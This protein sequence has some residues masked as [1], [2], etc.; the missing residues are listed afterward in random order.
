VS[1]NSIK[2]GVLLPQSNEHQYYPVSFLNGLRL[3]VNLGKQPDD[4]K[5]EV[6][7][8]QVN[9]GNPGITQKKVEQLITENKV[10]ML[11]GL[12]NYEVVHYIGDMVSSA[13]VPAIIAN[14]GENYL[15]NNLKENPYLFFN[16]LNLCRNSY[17]AGKYAVEKYGKKIVVV[18]ALYD[19]G[20]DALSAF[21]K[22][23]ESAGG[24]IIE[25][26]LKNSDDKEFVPKTLDKIENE[27]LDGIYVFL[28]GNLADEFFRTTFQRN[29]SVPVITTSFVTDDNRLVY[30]GKAAQGVHHFSTWGKNLNNKENQVFVA[31]YNKLFSK[32]PDQFGFLGYESGLIINNAIVKCR[33]DISGNNLANAIANCKIESPGGQISVNNKTGFV[34]NPAYLCKTKL[35]GYNVPENVILKQYTQVGEF[36]EN[37]ISSDTK[38]RSGFINPYLF[39]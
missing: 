39:V 7:T 29:L 34:N 10:K 21:Y 22:G 2:I 12:L 31:E 36:D 23:V 37:F 8:E 35:S 33:G 18:T 27:K 38:L 20:Y 25:T 32:M 16:T 13:Q 1:K 14:S 26:Y 28:N 9:Y 3:A 24:N 5:T 30:F 17:L 6:I 19:I 4:F 11:V 15:V